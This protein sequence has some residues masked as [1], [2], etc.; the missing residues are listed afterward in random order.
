MILQ[1]LITNS[2][3]SPAPIQ[4]EDRVVLASVLERIDSVISIANVTM[5]S[6]SADSGCFLLP[7]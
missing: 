4:R 2:E 3:L 1:T 6:G 5:Q 7:S